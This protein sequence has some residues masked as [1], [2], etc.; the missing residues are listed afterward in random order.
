MAVLLVSV[1]LGVIFAVFGTQNTAPVDLNFGGYVLAGVPMYLAVLIPLLIGLVLALFLHIARD[2]SQ[3]LT[4]SEQKDKIKNLKQEL[5]EVTKSAHKYQLESTRLKSE[6]GDS[7]D[8][9]SI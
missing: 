5:A 9:D 2:L 7:G 3:R 1:V 4:I 8:E 6:N